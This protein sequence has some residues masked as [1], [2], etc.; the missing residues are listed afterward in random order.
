MPVPEELL[1]IMQCPECAGN[2]R[3]L[4]D[5]PA[6]ECV[7]CGLRYPVEDDIPVMLP[8]E[9]YRPEASG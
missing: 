2:L 5:P 3:E 1:E 7:S 4:A 8:E 6:L 9:A